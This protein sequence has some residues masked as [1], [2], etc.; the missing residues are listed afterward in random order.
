M[1]CDHP[2]ENRNPYDIVYEETLTHKTVTI[3]SNCNLCNESRYDRTT[4]L[5]KESQSFQDVSRK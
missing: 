4:I 1:T 5:K 2:W 3:Y